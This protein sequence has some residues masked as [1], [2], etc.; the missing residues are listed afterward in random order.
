MTIL[1]LVLGTALFGVVCILL[2]FLIT[3]LLIR[4]A[5]PNE[6]MIVYGAGGTRVV[7]GGSATV[8]PYYQKAKYFSLELMSFTVDILQELY[9][10]E[11]DVYVNVETVVLIK[12]HT[13]NAD[14]SGDIE[15]LISKGQPK[16]EDLLRIANENPQQRSILKAAELF[17]DKSQSEREALIRM[18]IE[19]HLR[20]IIG[21]HS[22]DELVQDPE[23][24]AQA[25]FKSTAADLGRM[26]LEMVSFTMKG[27]HRLNSE[28][29]SEG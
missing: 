21:Q 10:A 18:V 6:A 22:F 28:Q 16:R 23:E 17:L 26:G 11:Q 9:R 15:Q 2:P 19:G 24:I 13:G 1:F 20:G 5:G 3:T 27:L 8:L 25:M 7:V 14:F 4:R 29:P 12:V